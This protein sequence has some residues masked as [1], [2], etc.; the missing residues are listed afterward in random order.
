MSGA[1]GPDERVRVVAA[2]IERDGHFLLGCRPAEKRHG[3]LWEFP[4][5]KLDVGEDAEQATIRELDEEMRLEVMSVGARLLSVEDPRSPFVIEFFEV[6]VRGEP[7]ALEHSDVA[8]RR[9]EELQQMPLAP[10]DAAFVRWLVDRSDRTR[11]GN[12]GG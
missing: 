10:A 7:L 4:G 6:T 1:G 9:V 11:P 8:W 3:G 12:A 5:G 2:V